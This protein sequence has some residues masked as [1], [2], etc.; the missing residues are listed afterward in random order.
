MTKTYEVLFFDLDNTLFDFEASEQEALLKT[1]I[2]YGYKDQPEA[3]IHA[4]HAVNKPLWQALE[5]G[6]ITSEFIKHERF[7]RLVDQLGISVEP[8][9]MSAFYVYTLGEGIDVLPYARELCGYLKSKYKMAAVTNGLKA[10][11]EKRLRLSEMDVFFDAVII[12]EEA[13]VSKPDPE[14]FEQALIKLGHTD[15]TTVL[16]IGDNLKADILGAKRAGIDGCWV[17][18]KGESAPVEKNYHW[19]IRHLSQLFEIL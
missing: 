6:E 18:L 16:M 12:S 15:K 2:H 10:V 5:R 14:I 13:G 4:Y 11:Q 19:E 9:E 7:K 1:A 3:F 8:T 17:N